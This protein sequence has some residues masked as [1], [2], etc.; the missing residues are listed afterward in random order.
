MCRSWNM[1]GCMY[2][3][4]ILLHLQPYW[5]AILLCWHW[6]WLEA[7]Y[8]WSNRGRSSIIAIGGEHLEICTVCVFDTSVIVFGHSKCIIT[9]FRFRF[10]SNFI[11]FV[12]RL[13]AEC[14]CCSVRGSPVLLASLVAILA[15]SALINK[16]LYGIYQPSVKIC[17]NSL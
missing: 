6:H 12:S 7:K 11:D 17:W 14:V 3:T 9:K 10:A 13:A 5:N 2:S 15:G 4:A 16:V 8:H 1:T